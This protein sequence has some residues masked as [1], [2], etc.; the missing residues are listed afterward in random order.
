MN[1]LWLATK[2]PW[3]PVDGG[4]LLSALT[5]D[6]LQQHSHRVTLVAPIAR[7]ASAV[8]AARDS[9]QSHVTELVPVGLGRVSPLVRSLAGGAPYT[10]LRHRHRAV[11]R[12]IAS[13][14]ERERFDVVHAEQL[15]AL[16][17][18]GASGTGQRAELP[19]VLRAQNVESDL[20]RQ[21]AS[22][23]ARLVALWMRR[24]ARRLSTFEGAACRR[25]AAVTALTAAD[26]AR[27]EQLSGRDDIA[28]IP[29]PF[30]DRLPQASR[31]LAGSPAVVLLGSGGWLPNRDAVDW[32]LA[33]VW[34]AVRS[35]L[36]G[37]ALHLFG[38]A[39]DHRKAQ[40]RDP[41]LRRLGVHASP[42]LA[43][44]RDAFG[45]GSILVVPLRLGSGVRIKILEAWARGIPVV[46]TPEA[47]AGLD[48]ANERDLL[49]GSS[50]GELAA[51]I[52]QVSTSP[53]LRG[54]L[55]AGGRQ[56]LTDRHDPGRTSERLVELYRQ[57]AGG[58]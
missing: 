34:P 24:E 35:V 49:L 23:A 44:S 55:I 19:T 25:L 12:T 11:Q 6:A 39:T 20:W 33:S 29:A 54:R 21:A 42:A 37:A 31:P 3:P 28:P 17:A 4:R 15:Q 22:V 13:L 32:F 9:Q 8:A 27:L 10:I 38:G 57:A 45:P 47:A 56:A 26:A 7:T 5:I 46:A 51:G 52:Q 53:E 41:G 18:L 30:P 16:G 14:L 36:P 50:P 48:A 43:D 2:P 40:Q 58:A 1:I